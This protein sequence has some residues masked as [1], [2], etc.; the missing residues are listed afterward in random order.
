MLTQL[1]VTAAWIV[2]LPVL[3]VVEIVLRNVLNVLLGIGKRIQYVLV[4]NNNCGS[5]M[6]AKASFVS[7]ETEEARKQQISFSRYLT[8]FGLCVSTCIILQK[9]VSIA[10]VLGVCVGIYITLA[11]YFAF[12]SDFPKEDLKEQLSGQLK[13][14]FG[15]Q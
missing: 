3:D 8:Y 15:T 5:K 13:Q 12:S 9:N 1:E 6:L 14:A 10:A 2:T 7:D 4:S 11:E